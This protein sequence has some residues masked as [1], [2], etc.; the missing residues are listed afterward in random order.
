ME[1]P[2]FVEEWIDSLPWY[3]RWTIRAGLHVGGGSCLLAL[4][5]IVLVLLA[6]M[7]ACGAI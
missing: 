2:D 7:K 6:L 4:L 1:I 5:I 3:R